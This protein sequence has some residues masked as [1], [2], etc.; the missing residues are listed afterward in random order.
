MAGACA[1]GGGL[2]GLIYFFRDLS[3]QRIL[4][5]KE[6]RQERTEK[7]GTQRPSKDASSQFKAVGWILDGQHCV[8][9]RES[10]QACCDI[11]V[12]RIVRQ[13]R[14]VVRNCCWPVRAC[15]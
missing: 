5:K 11:A 2:N 15:G 10:F 8:Q 6:K 13:G 14:H 1:L 7:N 9:R 3:L 4:K 12:M